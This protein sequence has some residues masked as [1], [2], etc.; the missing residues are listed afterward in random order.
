MTSAVKQA[1]WQWS[2]SSCL[3]LSGSVCGR[4]AD[5]T[6][7]LPSLRRD[8]DAD[9]QLRVRQDVVRGRD[10]FLVANT[11]RHAGFWSGPDIGPWT[12]PVDLGEGRWFGRQQ[13][14]RRQQQTTAEAALVEAAEV[15]AARKEGGAV[16]R[17]PADDANA[18]RVRYDSGM[19]AFG[20][21]VVDC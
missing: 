12:A 13:R 7:L 20:T 19:A 1:R 16:T 8:A 21:G 18:Y 17:L 6:D 11:T 4:A 9:C 5:G 2:W 14:W 15:M 3:I 10:D